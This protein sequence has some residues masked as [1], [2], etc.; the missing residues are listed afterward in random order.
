MEEIKNNRKLKFIP[1]SVTSFDNFIEEE[2]I[3]IN[4]VHEKYKGTIT[5]NGELIVCNDINKLNIIYNKM[6]K[7]TYEEYLKFIDSYNIEKD[8]WIYNIIDCICEQDKIIYRDKICIIIP[9]YTFNGIDINKLH[10]LSMPIDKSLRCLRDLNG[11]HI[12]LLL[13]MKNKTIEIILSKYGLNESNL[14][15]YIHYEPT[16]YHLHIHFVNIEFTEANS[17]VEYSHEIN[18][19]IY[20]LGIDYNYYQKIILNKRF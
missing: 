20:N 13:Y 2:V 19:I 16:T 17:S 3:F 9:T 5:I 6:K 7:E 11:S 8:K 18:S 4:D 14:K 10:I 12:N 1:N 15:I